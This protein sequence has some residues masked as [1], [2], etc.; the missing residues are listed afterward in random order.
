MPRPTPRQD[1][2]TQ[3]TTQTT[4]TNIPT[5]HNTNNYT[6]NPQHQQLYPQPTT[7]DNSLSILPSPNQVS[8]PT[9]HRQHCLCP[10][11]V[12][13]LQHSNS[14]QV[15]TNLHEVPDAYFAAVT[16]DTSCSKGGDGVGAGEVRMVIVIY[17][18]I[19]FFDHPIG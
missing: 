17:L 13:S 5:T 6:H 16:T 3:P 2:L 19:L 18:F 9:T 11:P 14:V 1:T 10:L 12:P 15:R 4:L 8:L 7:T